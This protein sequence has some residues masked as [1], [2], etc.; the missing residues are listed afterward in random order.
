MPG[1]ARKT[2]ALF[3]YAP[4]RIGLIHALSHFEP[5]AWRHGRKRFWPKGHRLTGTESSPWLVPSIGGGKGARLWLRGIF[6]WGE[7]GQRRP[8]SRGLCVRP[9]QGH[10]SWKADLSWGQ[11]LS[12]RVPALPTITAPSG[13]FHCPHLRNCNASS[14][15]YWTD[16]R[17]RCDQTGSQ[18]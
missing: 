7:K 5:R 18:R 1:T 9:P 13:K 6:T 10:V 14:N 2:C 17:C 3:S 16:E 8:Y 11:R 4:V 15:P 12:P